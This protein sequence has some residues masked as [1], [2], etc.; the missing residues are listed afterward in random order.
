LH[1]TIRVAD[2]RTEYMSRLQFRH[3]II[4][5]IAVLILY[6]L[7]SYDFSHLTK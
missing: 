7:R 6:V 2:A 4:G 1:I 5:L 3:L